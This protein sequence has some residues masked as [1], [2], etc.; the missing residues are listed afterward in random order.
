MF[1]IMDIYKSLSI[2]IAAVINNPEMLKYVAN[3]LKTKTNV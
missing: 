2:S 1:D 3:I